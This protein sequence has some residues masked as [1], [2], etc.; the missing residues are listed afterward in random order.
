LYCLFIVATAAY[1]F[2]AKRKD[3]IGQLAPLL[4]TIPFL[5]LPFLWVRMIPLGVCITLPL[6]AVCVTELFK[7]IKRDAPQFARLL[8]PLTLICGYLLICFLWI[9]PPKQIVYMPPVDQF[10]LIEQE[11]LSHSIL[12][13]T[14]IVGY[15]FWRLYRDKG[16]FDAQDYLFD[17]QDTIAIYSAY[18]VI[19]EQA[20]QQILTTYKM[21]TVMV[22]KNNDY[23]TG[24]FS[25]KSDWS[26][27]Y[28][29]YNGILFI[30]NDNAPENFIQTQALKTIDFS[31]DLGIDPK[32]IVPAIA[33]LER[34]IAAHPHSKLALGQLATLYRFH[35]EF[36]KAETTLN[37]IPAS[38]WDFV[39]M[40]EMGRIKG[41]QGACKQSESWFLKAL[42]ERN[43]KNISRTTFDL[44]ILY[45][46]CFND[47]AKAKH[48]FKRYTSYPIPDFERQRATLIMQK[49]VSN[50]L[51]DT[52]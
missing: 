6:F 9:S 13:S 19:S 34:F 36:G 20:I 41:A 7:S 33:E 52:K 47:S 4:P 43:E 10:D 51:E 46:V 15:A 44:A 3:T 18:N 12:V 1:L 17:E 14:D 22:S 29:D 45:A 2:V 49:Y 11:H 27:A 50:I 32:N 35:N 48:Y 38:E 28:I 21:T 40:T 23:L 8:V 42:E 37:K 16:Y 24:Y 25:T 31:K 30:Q 5:L 39:V 26:T